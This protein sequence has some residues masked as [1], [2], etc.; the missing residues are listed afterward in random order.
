ELVALDRHVAVLGDFEPLDDIAGRH[1]SPSSLFAQTGRGRSLFPLRWQLPPPLTGHAR[2]GGL[3][4][5][6]PLAR[7]GWVGACLDDFLVAD[8]LPAEAVDLVEA[9]VFPAGRRVEAHGHADQA[10]TDRPRP[11]CPRHPLIM[12]RVRSPG[13]RR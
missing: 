12:A 8:S 2:G 1:R 9:D 6:F 13:Y 3:Q 10:E 7:E 4:P 11:D 5:R